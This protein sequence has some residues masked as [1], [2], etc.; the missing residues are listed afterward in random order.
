MPDFELSRFQD[1]IDDGVKAMLNIGDDHRLPHFIY[2][3]N[4]TGYF[5]V[6]EKIILTKMKKYDISSAILTALSMERENLITKEEWKAAYKGELENEYGWHIFDGS[7]NDNLEWFSNKLQEMSNPEEIGEGYCWSFFLPKLTEE[8]LQELDVEEKTSKILREHDSSD[9]YRKN[10]CYRRTK[11]LKINL[12]SDTSLE[13]ASEIV[14][15]F[16]RKCSTPPS[17]STETSS[18]TLNETEIE[19]LI[20]VKTSCC[21]D[22]CCNIS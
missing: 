13:T 10:T 11:F 6:L 15:E 14:P 7:I 12:L 20:E 3:S 4:S 5:S 22:S 9:I 1:C 17:P 2:C 19:T 21:Y 18:E 8:E 16:L